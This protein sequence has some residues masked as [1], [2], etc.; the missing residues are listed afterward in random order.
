[1]QAVPDDASKVAEFKN[2]I[3]LTTEFETG[4]KEMMFISPTDNKDDKLSA[5]AQ[6]VEVHFAS[7]KKNEIL[8]K[9]RNLL[10]QSEF[11]LSLVSTLC[12]N[13]NLSL[14]AWKNHKQLSA[15]SY[16]RKI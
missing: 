2:I 11:V 5:F 4:L 9:A 1:M 13:A 15:D 7:R 10:L 12:T 14:I 16:H 3:K 6:N 8:G